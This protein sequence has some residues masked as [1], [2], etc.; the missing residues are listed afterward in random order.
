MMIPAARYPSALV[1]EQPRGAER[2]VAAPVTLPVARLVLGVAMFIL[3]PSLTRSVRCNHLAY[4]VA[5][6]FG[7]GLV[8]LR[9]IPPPR[10]LGLIP[11][12]YGVEQL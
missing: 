10:F 3:P 2:R 6:V 4:V 11:R 1:T 8:G 5:Q 12:P 9:Q 7:R